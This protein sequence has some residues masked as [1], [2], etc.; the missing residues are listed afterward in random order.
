MLKNT[1]FISYQW[2]RYLNNLEPVLNRHSEIL[3]FLVGV[4]LTAFVLGL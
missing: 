4:R 3:I 2:T 1:N